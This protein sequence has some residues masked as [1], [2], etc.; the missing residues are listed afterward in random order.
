MSEKKIKT[1]VAFK[2][3]HEMS[4]AKFKELF[5]SSIRAIER[6]IGVM[7]SHVIPPLDKWNITFDEEDGKTTFKITCHYVPEKIGLVAYEPEDEV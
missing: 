6:H 3:E 4:V 2:C 5:D 1:G 7:K